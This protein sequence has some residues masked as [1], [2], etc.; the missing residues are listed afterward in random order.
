M[1]YA[2]QYK[3][4]RTKLAS[5]MISWQLSIIAVLVEG[6]GCTMFKQMWAPPTSAHLCFYFCVINFTRMHP[7][8]CGHQPGDASCMSYLCT[9][10][11]C[12]HMWRKR[13]WWLL[14]TFRNPVQDPKY[15]RSLQYQESENWTW[16]THT[17]K[18][19]H[20]LGLVS[21]LHAVL[22]LS[23][24][25]TILPGHKQHVVSPWHGIHVGKVWSV[26]C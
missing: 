16:P 19:L 18:N 23:T 25:L 20:H 7:T 14:G 5:D 12:E 3:C 24:V 26:Q 15:S 11:C 8:E 13:K 22:F 17:T 9:L 10:S 1:I 2:L 6:V 21:I 4:E